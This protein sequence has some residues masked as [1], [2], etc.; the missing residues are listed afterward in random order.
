[1][2]VCV[3]GGATCDLFLCFNIL[4]IRQCPPPPSAV[5]ESRST[6]QNS[7]IP[8]FYFSIPISTVVLNLGST[9]RGSL[10]QSQ[11]FVESVSGDRRVSLR[12]LLSQSQ[13]IVESV[14]G[15][16]RVSLRGSLSLPQGIVESVSG[17]RRVSLRGSAEVMNSKTIFNNTSKHSL[18][19]VFV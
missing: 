17:V 10:S 3:G 8:L 18:S 6:R 19:Y 1:M 5:F 13:G 16:R 7:K 15:D 9:P 14:S 2:C 12:G 11:G 4:A